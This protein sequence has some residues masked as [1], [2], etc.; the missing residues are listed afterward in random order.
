MFK[1]LFGEGDSNNSGSNSG[2]NAAGGV[3]GA[4][5]SVPP[6]GAGGDGGV[7]GR[8]SSGVDDRPVAPLTKADVFDPS[9][10][11]RIA[12]AARDLKD[13]PNAKD[14]IDLAKVQEKSWQD[15]FHAAQKEAEAKAKEY[16]LQAIHLAEEEKR[17]TLKAQT[18][19]SNQRA[20]YQDQLAR[21]RYNDQLQQQQQMQEQ[22]LRA[23]EV[24]AQRQEAERRRTLEYEAELRKETE[25]VK[26]RA[27]AEART[28]Q[29]RENRD[30]RDAQLVLTAEQNR[31]TV[32]EG[33][34]QAGATIG[35]GIRDFL[36]DTKKIGAT[37]GIVTAIAVGVYAA[38]SGTKVTADYV[39]QRLQKP[40]LVRETSRVNPVLSPVKWI[41]QAVGRQS[42]NPLD[43]MVLDA[44]T[45]SRLQT[46]TLATAHTRQHKGN[47]RHIMLYG[48]PGT[49]KTMFA[50]RLAKQS[51]MDYAILAGGDVGPL[52]RDAVTEIHRVFDWAQ[53]SRRGLVI[54]V[55]EADAFLRKRGLQ[56]DGKMTE[57]T[58]NAL[59]TFLYRTGDPT[60]KF[61][62]VFSTNEPEAFDPAVVDRVDEVVKLDLPGKIERE[63]LLD[64]YFKE[65]IVKGASGARPIRV[66]EDVA[67]GPQLWSEL[68][69]R[70]AGF[71]GRQI[72]K[73]A[74]AW[75]AQAYASVDNTLTREMLFSVLDNHLKGLATK[76]QWAS[77]SLP[78]SR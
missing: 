73:L 50:R 34:R 31:I 6:P 11:E 37:V 53:H 70:T 41:R 65:Y 35:E 36:S 12:A 47:F 75:Q 22:Q 28:R 46:V 23:Q 68:A 8:L 77:T 74:N 18:E 63:Q 3:I 55:D 21:K 9:I 27:E 30:I 15:K 67:P 14:L 56:S 57:D 16:E 64:L 5:G 10:L 42:G 62:L 78:S 45:T 39:A 19:E 25:L 26:V 60:N 66:A 29:E 76:Q 13:L 54:F 1:W 61:M 43:G 24:S 40:P 44:N 49:G 33:I 2:G 52:G 72:S 71:S 20:Q 4:G 69:A 48:P 59:S 51:G 38:R 7:A 17:K 32:L 58:R